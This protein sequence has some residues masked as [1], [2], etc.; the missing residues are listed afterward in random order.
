MAVIFSLQSAPKS[1]IPPSLDDGIFL[2]GKGPH[3]ILL[4]H[5]LTGS[6]SEMA[7]VA[8][9]FHREGYTVFVPRIAGHGDSIFVLKK[10]KWGI[11]Y[12]SVRTAFEKLRDECGNEASL[13]VGG[14]SMGALLALLLAREYADEIA[15]VVSFS[16]TLFFD[17]WNVPW[18]QYLLPIAFH[19]PLK[20]C[21]YFREEAPYGLKSEAARRHVDASYRDAKLEDYSDASRNGYAFFPVALFCELQRLIRYLIPRLAEVSAPIQLLQATN[22]D[23]TSVRNSEFILQKVRSKIK[24]LILLDDSYHVITA[25]Q[26]RYIVA[27]K[28]IAFCNRIASPLASLT[29]NV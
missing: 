17:G 25:D 12:D 11:F 19:T 4:I 20:H 27:E 29:A 7:F 1:H 5:G 18:T 10:K 2:K 23:M 6:P 16:A 14:L 26:E 21:F 15:G 13:F 8:R 9:S 24:E 22:D 28:A 3:A